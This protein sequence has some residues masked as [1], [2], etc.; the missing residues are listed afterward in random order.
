MLL[1]LIWIL[2]IRHWKCSSS[3]AVV[4]KF[5][6]FDSYIVTWYTYIHVYGLM[7]NLYCINKCLSNQVHCMHHGIMVCSYN[8]ITRMYCHLPVS[9][10]LIRLV[11]SVGA[12]KNI[13]YTYSVVV[14]WIGMASHLLPWLQWLGCF[15]H[16][17]I[18]TMGSLWL[19]QTLTH[20]K[21][22]ADLLIILHYSTSHGS[23]NYIN[24]IIVTDHET[25]LMCMNK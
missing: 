3:A 4:C 6:N 22:V 21:H 23:N 14:Q 24:I 20:C 7:Q 17:T 10:R 15:S 16:V 12:Y 5:F 2:V 1:T 13:L 11:L 19:S 18:I 8:R 9:I 25:T